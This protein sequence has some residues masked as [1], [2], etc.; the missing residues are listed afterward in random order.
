M[1]R[2]ILLAYRRKSLVRTDSD[3]ISP[4]RQTKAVEGRAIADDLTC[5]WY[6]DVDGHRSARRNQRRPASC[7]GPARPCHLRWW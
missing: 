1:T 3:R 7:D 6:E 2:H 4:A 5:E